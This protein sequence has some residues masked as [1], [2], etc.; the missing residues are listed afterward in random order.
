MIVNIFFE[1]VGIFLKEFSKRLIV[2]RKERGVTQHQLCAATGI[3]VNGY[4]KIERGESDPTL[5]S[6]EALADFFDV[7]I[8]FLVGRSNVESP[9]TQSPAN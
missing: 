6:V 5:S 7:S 8:D 1:K 2:L 3:S 9:Q 4:G